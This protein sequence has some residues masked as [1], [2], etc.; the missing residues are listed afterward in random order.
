MDAR[1]IDGIGGASVNIVF[2]KGVLD[3]WSMVTRGSQRERVSERC[4]YKEIDLMLLAQKDTSFRYSIMRCFGP[5]SGVCEF[6]AGYFLRSTYLPL[7]ILAAHFL[8]FA[9]SAYSTAS[10]R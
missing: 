4:S 5:S 10:D 2:D 7:V 1:K 3:A 6:M 9:D 8:S